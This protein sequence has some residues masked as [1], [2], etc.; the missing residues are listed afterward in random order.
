MLQIFEIIVPKIHEARN[1]TFSSVFLFFTV[2][3][4]G[5]HSPAP[6]VD[7]IIADSSF[8]KSFINENFFHCFTNLPIAA[9][10]FFLSVVWSVQ[11]PS[12]AYNS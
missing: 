12:G 7:G 9:N 11:V 3:G 2:V 10:A 5:L 4:A 1:L 8:P 6:A